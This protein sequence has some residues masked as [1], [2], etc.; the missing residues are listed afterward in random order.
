MS[1]SP[2]VRAIAA[3]PSTRLRATLSAPRPLL[4]STGADPAHGLPAHV[5]A[6]SAIRRRGSRLVIVQDDVNAIAVLDPATRSTLPLLLPAGPNGARVFDDA[7]GNK[8]Q[9]L[10]LEACVALPDGRLVA[11]GSGSSLQRERLVIIAADSGSSVQVVEAGELY[12]ELRVHAEAR[13][14]EINIEGAVV[15]G[16]RLR[17]L[18]R[19]NGKH[20]STPWNAILDLALAEFLDWLDDRDVHPKVQHILEVD[21][22]AIEGVPLGFTDATVTADG[23]MA[24]LACAEDSADALSDGPVLGCRFGWLDAD[25]RVATTTVVVDA[26]GKPTGLKLEGIEAS[27]GGGRVFDVVADMDRPDEP[28]QIA[29]LTVRG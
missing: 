18:Q 1:R 17:L 7:H 2:E 5:R 19:G 20:D 28:A 10:D 26:D 27:S 25:D 12:A 15:Q 23:R 13:G 9:K 8:K 21:L 4:Y 6:A 24:F 3:S 16:K 22:G 11:M 29:E 14:A